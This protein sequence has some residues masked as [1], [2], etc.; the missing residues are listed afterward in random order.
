MPKKR[1][2]QSPGG[3]TH[4]TLTS[5]QGPIN[6]MKNNVRLAGDRALNIPARR[7]ARLSTPRRKQK[8]HSPAKAKRGEFKPAMLYSPAGTIS[9]KPFILQQD[10]SNRQKQPWM[11][12]EE[13][14]FVLAPIAEL[15]EQLITDMPHYYAPNT[16][17]NDIASDFAT[18]HLR[19]MH[20]VHWSKQVYYVSVS[21]YQKKTGLRA[22]S[23][24]LIWWI[25]DDE[26]PERGQWSDPLI[27]DDTNDEEFHDAVD[28]AAELIAESGE[29]KDYENTGA[30]PRTKPTLRLKEGEVYNG[31]ALE[32]MDSGQ[33]IHHLMKRRNGGPLHSTMMMKYPR[34]KNWLNPDWID[35]R[36]VK[37]IG[38]GSYG[39]VFEATLTLDGKENRVAVK[40]G[41]LENH[42]FKIVLANN[43][44]AHGLE[45][46]H[47][48]LVTN[49][50]WFI[51]GKWYGTVME[52]MPYDLRA[53]V[54]ASSAMMN[55]MTAHIEAMKLLDERFSP[56]S[57]AN[58][59]RGSSS[60]PNNLA[61]QRAKAHESALVV[62]DDLLSEVKSHYNLPADFTPK[63]IDEILTFIAEVS[64]GMA[65]L[66]K[67]GLIH[68]DIK[69][70][71]VMISLNGV[72]KIGDFGLIT[73]ASSLDLVVGGSPVYMPD[74]IADERRYTYDNPS[75]DVFA[76]AQM[77]VRDVT[78]RF[79]DI[80]PSVVE[81][82]REVRH[83]WHE[84]SAEEFRNQLTGLAT[85]V[86]HIDNPRHTSLDRHRGLQTRS[87]R[88]ANHVI[89]SIETMKQSLV[90]LIKKKPKRSR[91]PAKRH[92]PPRPRQV[93]SPIGMGGARRSP[94][95]PNEAWQ[96]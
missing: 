75:I 66:H 19:F 43:E 37:Q 34:F 78:P 29:Y 4:A 54:R 82:A 16:S 20:D 13:H 71:N 46:N 57:R 95:R 53:V 85:D 94:R 41:R 15:H 25:G 91:T 68:R 96:Q 17:W 9:F 80:Q 63:S 39:K 59:P 45:L 28:F 1:A 73:Y 86:I 70:A 76:I 64:S 90:G 18:A 42:L 36:N 47:P 21:L 87:K 5:F 32:Y 58:G 7:S 74:N 30:E 23:T 48:N 62:L 77:I 89:D 38:Q 55:G 40:V 65:Y 24:F 88:L 72:A 83:N 52:F 93:A 44:T 2:T 14:R 10:A 50:G 11:E 60:G 69:P 35:W 3:M 61:L 22:E 67:Q 33:S 79:E 31:E 12:E 81:L 27:W 84:W 56:S 6:A 49:Y 26:M 92:S 8:I 51:V